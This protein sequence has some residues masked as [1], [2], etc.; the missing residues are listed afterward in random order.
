ME[1]SKVFSIYSK[2][3]NDVFERRLLKTFAQ[4]VVNSDGDKKVDDLDKQS[5]K[6][7]MFNKN[8][9][10]PKM[11]VGSIPSKLSFAIFKKN[12]E[13]ERLKK[14]KKHAEILSEKLMNIMG[15]N[16]SYVGNWDILSNSAVEF[17][18]TLYISLAA[19]KSIS[20]AIKDKDVL[21][22]KGSKLEEEY[23]DTIISTLSTIVRANKEN[24]EAMLEYVKGHEFE[25]VVKKN[26]TFWNKKCIP[27]IIKEFKK[28][29]IDFIVS[30]QKIEV[31][32]EDSDYKVKKRKYKYF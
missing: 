15:N 26:V 12:P 10:I 1:F 20:S 13:K 9:A 30:V 4:K 11:M 14:I 22:L 6:G 3:G 23:F 19:Y 17:L 18:I 27:S 25:Q 21:K 32:K 7:N 16:F 29:L 5:K 28:A 8:M 31:V 24:V 2:Q